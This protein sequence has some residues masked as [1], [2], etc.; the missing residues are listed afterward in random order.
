MMPWR[1][2]KA[3]ARV[4]G[5]LC[6]REDCISVLRLIEAAC[7]VGV[8]ARMG[9]EP[10]AFRYTLVWFHDIL[11]RTFLNHTGVISAPGEAHCQGRTIP[12]LLPSGL[13]I[14]R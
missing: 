11:D 4:V 13:P 8:P 7:G 10:P 2:R 6:F 12:P 14:L 5:V 3:R 1:E 9:Q